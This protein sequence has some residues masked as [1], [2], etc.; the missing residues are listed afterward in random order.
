[1]RSD[2]NNISVYEYIAA[3]CPEKVISFLASKGYKSSGGANAIAAYKN[4][5]Q[6]LGKNLLETLSN[7]QVSQQMKSGAM[8][9]IKD[10]SANLQKFVN[11]GREPALK[12]VMLNLHPDK[13]AFMA[14]LPGGKKLNASGKMMNCCGS[15][16]ADGMMNC[17]GGTC[18]CS[19]K[20]ED[21]FG[22]A[23]ES[24]PIYMNAA[25]LP[26]KKEQAELSVQT[27]PSTQTN[28]FLLATTGLMIIG[29]VAVLKIGDNR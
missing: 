20:Y 10:A 18:S 12:E 25:W 9:I 16:N 14:A 5:P 3:K 13:E 11:D 4:A 27:P 17:D 6:L 7:P 15:S 2:Y 22:P 24:N 29:L 26:P 19:K 8:F 23:I 1:M 21:G 28:W